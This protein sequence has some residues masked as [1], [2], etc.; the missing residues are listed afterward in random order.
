MSYITSTFS[1]A[2]KDDWKRSIVLRAA[3]AFLPTSFESV[4]CKFVSVK[5][6]PE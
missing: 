5:S 2:L 1:T 6:R 4:P 3:W